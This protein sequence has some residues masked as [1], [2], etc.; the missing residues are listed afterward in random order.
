VHKIRSL[1]IIGAAVASFG[2]ASTAFGQAV[3]PGTGKQWSNTWSDEFNI[4]QGDLTGWT[5]DLGGGGW[6]NN[7]KE[8]YTNSTNNV[9]VNAEAGTGIGALH[10]DAI[11]TGSGASQ[12]YTSGRIKT[13]NLFSQAYGL[14]EFRAKLPAGQGLWPALW[15]MPKDSAYGGWPTSGE[16]DVLESTGQNTGL[17]QGSLHSGSSPGTHVTQTKT[18]SQSGSEPAGFA[19]TAWHT[20]D[21]LWDQGSSNNAATFNWYVDGILYETQHGGWFIPTTAVPQGTNKDAPFD[22]PFY[23]IMNLAVGGDYVGNPNIAAGTYGMQVDYARAYQRINS[24]GTPSWKNDVAGNWSTAGNWV[25]GVV[26]NSSGAAALLGGVLTQPRSVTID[27]PITVGSLTFDSA[28]SYTLGG[29]QTI[30]FDTTGPSPVATVLNGSHTI[31]APVVLNRSTIFALATASSSLSVASMSFAS[32]VSLTK[33]GPGTL[34]TKNIRTAGGLT[35]SAGSVQILADG[36]ASGLSTLST[37]SIATDG[38]LDLT[39]NSLI[40]DYTG[41]VGTRIDDIRQ[42]LAAGRLDSSTADAVHRL[43]YGD[44]AVLGKASLLGQTLDAS[45]VVVTYAFGGDANLD[46]QV[47]VTDLGKLATSWQTSGVWT[48]GDFNYD[49]FIDVSD[50]GILA[51]NWQAGVAGAPALGGASFEQAAALFGISSV[52]E[53]ATLGCIGFALLVAARRRR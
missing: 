32:G 33:T 15:M 23:I 20:Y 48:G 35:V 26:P 13:T 3:S 29:T 2:G 18:F 49:G 52:P 34:A 36:T 1:I 22:K 51:S 46:G 27:A 4:G 43:G 5:Y 10:I 30:T 40:L 24:I 38:V 19:T 47:D 45:S 14:F 11:A 21:L 31:N 25:S 6:G 9:H 28:Q 39:N 8:V 12:T 17:V 53:P 42:H 44:N 50:L 7:E 16:I 37:L 41:A